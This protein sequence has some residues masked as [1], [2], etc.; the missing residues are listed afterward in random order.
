M[1]TSCQQ[2]RFILGRSSDLLVKE[3]HSVVLPMFC[4]ATSKASRERVIGK[5][6]IQTQSVRP[7]LTRVL[8]PGIRIHVRALE[9]GPGNT[10]QLR[11]LALWNACYQPTLPPPDRR[12]LLHRLPASGGR[13]FWQLQ[14]H[15]REC[16]RAPHAR[17]TCRHGPG[18]G[19]GTPQVS[20]S[21]RS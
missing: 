1:C 5:Q 18:L 8:L 7:I 21:C 10:G 3:H 9:G 19:P 2:Y 16:A 14:L 4:D 6:T 11:D 17:R 15:A 13:V 12:D 20:Q